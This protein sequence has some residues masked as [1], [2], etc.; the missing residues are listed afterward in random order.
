MVAAPLVRHQLAVRLHHDRVEVL[1]AVVLKDIKIPN[2]RA[3]QLLWV[4]C[5]I[6]DGALDPHGGWAQ[7]SGCVNPALSGCEKCSRN[8]WPALAPNSV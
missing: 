4:T 8:L 1:H 7:I 5:E 6:L 2:E 3:G